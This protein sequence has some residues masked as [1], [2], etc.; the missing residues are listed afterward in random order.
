MLG[1]SMLIGAKAGEL[2]KKFF[3]C[4]WSTYEEEFKDNLKKLLKHGTKSME[5]LLRYPVQ[6]WARAY[7]SN[8]CKSE[9]VDDN[10]SN[11]FNS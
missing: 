7:C 2:K 11:I 5:D 6:N 3:S 1:T 4:A 8:K 10:V 9:M